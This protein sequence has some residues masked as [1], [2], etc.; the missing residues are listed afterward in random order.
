MRILLVTQSPER[1]ASEP[2]SPA[3]ALRDLGC[4][5]IATDFDLHLD[6]DALSREPPQVLVI[7]SR[8]RLE[9]G[10]ACLRALR[11]RAALAEVPALVALVV[12]RL[13][14]LDFRM[15]DDFVLV[16]VVPAELYARLRQLDQRFA[17]FSG[18]E[19]LKA[20]ELEIDL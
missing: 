10:Y 8:E 4:N 18:D 17:A 14:A 15:A 11:E 12:A 7:D 1:A 13:P 19:R 3:Q 6:E 16:P 9:T 20:N 2:E 5:V